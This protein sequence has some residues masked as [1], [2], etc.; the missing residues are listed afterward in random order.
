MGLDIIIDCGSPLYMQVWITQKDYGIL[1][2]GRFRQTLQAAVG[3]DKLRSHI[4]PGHQPSRMR[5]PNI[6]AGGSIFASSCRSYISAAAY[7]AR[8]TMPEMLEALGRMSRHVNEWSVDHDASLMHSFGYWK[9]AIER[10][11][12]YLIL[13]VTKEDSIRNNLSIDIYSDADHASDFSRRS[14]PQGQTALYFKGR[15]EA[16]PCSV[17]RRVGNDACRGGV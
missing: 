9:G 1:W 8:H 15:Q 2:V 13:R 11:D 14:T 4:T 7:A 5:A 3:S 17:E 6:S 12:V 10:D 16:T